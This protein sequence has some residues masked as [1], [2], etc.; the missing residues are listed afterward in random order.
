MDGQLCHQRDWGHQGLKSWLQHSSDLIQAPWR[1]FDAHG[2]KYWSPWSGSLAVCCVDNQHRHQLGL[3][4]RYLSRWDHC[5]PG[6]CRRPGCSTAQ[7]GA[8]DYHQPGSNQ[9]QGRTFSGHRLQPFRPRRGGF[10]SGSLGWCTPRADSKS[11]PRLWPGQ[12]RPTIQGD[13]LSLPWNAL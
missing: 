12:E 3:N 9:C 2:V 13:S 7:I 5:H 8:E 4:H 6:W 1:F 11:E 10:R